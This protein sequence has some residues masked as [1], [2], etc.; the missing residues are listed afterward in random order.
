MPLFS[1]K[2]LVKV[3]IIYFYALE[4]GRFSCLSLF[5]KNC[6]IDK[7]KQTKSDEKD[8]EFKKGHGLAVLLDGGALD[9]IEQQDYYD[10]RDW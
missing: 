6:F 4:K 7:S 1:D 5:K 8:V 2:A 9:D 10:F 3:C